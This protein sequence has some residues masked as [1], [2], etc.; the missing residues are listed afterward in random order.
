MGSVQFVGGLGSIRGFSSLD[1][2]GVLGDF[3]GKVL[4]ILLSYFAFILFHKTPL[5]LNIMVIK[6]HPK[7]SYALLSYPKPTHKTYLP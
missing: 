3:F 4:M 7:P 1:V 2:G 5:S 6:Y